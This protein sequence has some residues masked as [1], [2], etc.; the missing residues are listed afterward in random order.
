MR[1][2]HE[3]DRLHVRQLRPRLVDH[4]QRIVNT[5]R[6]E[7]PVTTCLQKPVAESGIEFRPVAE[8][9]DS[10]F[11]LPCRAIEL[12]PPQVR[13][14]VIDAE[15]QERMSFGSHEPPAFVLLN[16]EEAGRVEGLPLPTAKAIKFDG[17]R[18]SKYA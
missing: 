10:Q 16:S 17:V 12:L 5:S 14:E 7:T 8:I 18:C 3:L 4:V 11:L 6:V 2:L 13:M 9:I 15:T 1:D